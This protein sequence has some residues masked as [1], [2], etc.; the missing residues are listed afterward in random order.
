M[1]GTISIGDTDLHYTVEGSGE[2]FLF[3]HG[4]AASMIHGEYLSKY[5][6]K[7]CRFISYSQ[8]FH[9]PN[10]PSARGYYHADQHADDLILLLEKL[11]ITSCKILGHSYG[12]M[13]VLT[14]AVKKPGLFSSIFLAEPGLAFLLNGKE[15]YQELLQE[16]HDAFRRI[17]VCFE[18]GRSADA[19]ATLMRYANGN[20]GFRTFPE[21]IRQDMTANAGALYRLVYERQ[22]PG[23]NEALLTQLKTPVHLFLGSQCSAIYK[24]I[25]SEIKN[26]IPET[27]IIYIDDCAHDLIYLKTELWRYLAV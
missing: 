9:L 21:V 10:D 23:L 19:V 8:R 26:L 6:S 17:K 5:L 22:T 16:R 3:V 1:N 12:G 13:V 18:E 24:A 2:P 15:I 27:H 7:A 4:A 11:N 20:R 14:A 25:A